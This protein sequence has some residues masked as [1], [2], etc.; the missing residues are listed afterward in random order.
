MYLFTD[1]TVEKEAVDSQVF[2]FCLFVWLLWQNRGT[3]S[4]KIVF[5]NGLSIAVLNII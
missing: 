2:Y 3:G 5:L 4:I 1:E